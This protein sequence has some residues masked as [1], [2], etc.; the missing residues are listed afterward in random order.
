MSCQSTNFILLFYV[1]RGSDIE[2]LTY[3]VCMDIT[4]IS[5]HSIVS[6]A[7]GTCPVN[8]V[9]PAEVAAGGVVVW[10]SKKCSIGKVVTPTASQQEGHKK[11]NDYTELN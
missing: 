9:M 5:R 3:T 7:E 11:L 1:W 10:E 2:V 4:A 6:I 8:V